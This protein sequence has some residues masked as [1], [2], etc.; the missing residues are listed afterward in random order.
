MIIREKLLASIVSPEA[1]SLIG[2]LAIAIKYGMTVD[3]VTNIIH[4]FLGWSE[5]IRA[6]AYRIK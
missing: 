2:E 4:P 3:E 6:A 5:A 1:S